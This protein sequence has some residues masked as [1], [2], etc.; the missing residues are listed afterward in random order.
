LELQIDI[1]EFIVPPLISF[2]IN[3]EPP[4]HLDKFTTNYIFH[5]PEIDAGKHH[6]HDVN[7]NFWEY[8]RHEE[9]TD[10]SAALKEQI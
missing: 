1:S 8:D 3:N 10:N 7:E 5:N 9:I 2:V 6:H 4:T